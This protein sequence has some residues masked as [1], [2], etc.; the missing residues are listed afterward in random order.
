VAL[1]AIVV[2][3]MA[4]YPLTPSNVLPLAVK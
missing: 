2:V 3:A 4:F 1:C